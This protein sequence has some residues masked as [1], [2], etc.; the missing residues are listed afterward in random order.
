MTVP[1][2]L[3]ADQVAERLREL[4]GWSGDRARIGK[5]YA[6]GYHEGVRMVVEVAAAAKQMG[7]HPA[8]DIRWDRLRFTLTTHDAGN[9]V[10]ELDFA[11]ARRIDEI[12]AH[13]S[14]AG[15]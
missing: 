9:Q 12:A 3:R 7:H 6:I 11:S 10:T 5:T 15:A 1:E 14:A 4:E 8:I 2:P 13:H